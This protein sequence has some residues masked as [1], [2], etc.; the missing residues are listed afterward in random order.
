MQEAH[1]VVGEK[2]LM[3]E[4]AHP[5]VGEK[6]A[7]FG[8]GVIGLLVTAILARSFGAHSVLAVEPNAERAALSRRMGAGAVAAPESLSGADAPTIDVSVEVSG[9]ARAL[10]SCLDTTAK[11]GRV[12]LGSWYGENAAPLRLGLAFHRSHLSIR[13]SQVSEI[14]AELSGRW[15]KAR[16]FEEAWAWV[17]RLRPSRTLSTKVVPLREA[18]AAYDLLDQGATVGVHFSY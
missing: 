17:R 12:I 3:S 6:V 16:R 8:Q 10:Q 7:V 11:G 4:E 13:C 5:V 1:P 18:Q 9:S 14:P 2:V 15:D